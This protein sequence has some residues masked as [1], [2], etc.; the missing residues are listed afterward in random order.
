MTQASGRPHIGPKGTVCIS[1]QPTYRRTTAPASSNEVRDA[2]GPIDRYVCSIGVCDMQNHR[3]KVFHE[4][5]RPK[6]LDRF[7]SKID[8]LE[9]VRDELRYLLRYHFAGQQS[10]TM[11]QIE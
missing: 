10:A 8:P 11:D 9:E 7:K 3:T 4:I 6:S 5:E 1:E 2:C